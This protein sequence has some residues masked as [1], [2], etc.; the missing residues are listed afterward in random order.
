MDISIILE[1]K[2]R[3]VAKLVILDGWSC[4]GVEWCAVQCRAGKWNGKKCSAVK[5][6]SVQCNAVQCNALQSS[7][8]S[9]VGVQSAEQ[10][11]KCNFRL[12]TA[13]DCDSCHNKYVER[14]LYTAHWELHMLQ[15]FFMLFTPHVIPH[16]QDSTLHTTYCWPYA[17]HS[18][19]HTLSSILW[20]VWSALYTL[21]YIHST[22]YTLHSTL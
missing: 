13:V 20:T 12:T 4:S 5:L 22:L 2:S 9:T 10:S 1:G 7:F 3:H 19:L 14:P 18:K 16:T 6:S 11:K 21:H 15:R 17:L 8:F